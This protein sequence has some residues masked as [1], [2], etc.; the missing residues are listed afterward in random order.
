MLFF[1][2]SSV[3]ARYNPPAQ[4]IMSQ[5]TSFTSR[6]ASG[7]SNFSQVRVSSA[8]SSRG[9]RGSLKKP[10][11]F[12]SASLFNVGSTS[13]RIAPSYPV[14]PGY[15]GGIQEVTI[16]PS[17]LS[18]LNLRIDPD[19]YDVR[20]GEK[21]QIKVLNNKFATF[22]D[23]VRFLEQQNKILETKW[24]LL[25]QQKTGTRSNIAP[26]F[27][28]YI[29]NLRRQ[30]ESLHNDKGRLEG[31]MK[32]M[33]DLV[34]D[35]KNKYE[36]EI[37][38][39]TSAENEFVVLKK[40]V[41]ASYMNK[42]ELEAKVDGLTDEINFLRALYE[43]E[44]NEMQAQISDTSVVL[45]MDNNRNLDLD[46]IIA[47]V[48]A[49]YEDI[50]KKSRKEAETWYQSKF[51]VLQATAGK[52]GDDLRNTKNEIAEINRTILRMQ[53]EIDNVKNQRAKLEAAIA[54]AEERG[55]L[56]VKDARRKLEELEMAL[57]KAKQD[58]AH[59]LR[60]YQELMN[61]KLALD[62]EI[63][64]YRKLLEGEE[65]RLSEDGAGFVNMA[66][67]SYSGGGFN[68]GTGMG[69]GVPGFTP[70]GVSGGLKSTYSVKSTSRRSVR[71]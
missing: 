55:T 8:S 18:P 12:G 68:L 38:R 70:G 23:K 31:E 69:S 47:E 50:A 14:S 65:S 25:Q 16:N 9:F 32:N 61:V 39:R 17:L 67:Q 33:Q 56:A 59:Q 1:S 7:P 26:L 20:K 66:I 4:A 29:N 46:S 5:M 58:M 49:Q 41:D 45:Q 11:G 19:I 71:N 52:H 2:S 44:L 13:R 24:N 54:E 42:V 64:T 43:T 53:A 35:F 30:L 40:D 6:S 27:E 60:E 3:A 21:E 51:E 62:I 15:G 57:N 34:E 37:N 22:I 48:K 63:A 36:D 28:V 10:G